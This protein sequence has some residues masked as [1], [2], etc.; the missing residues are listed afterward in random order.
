MAKGSTVLLRLG[1]TLLLVGA[2]ARVVWPDQLSGIDETFVLLVVVA[3]AI[4]LVPWDSLKTFKA[5][6]VELT[7]ERAAVQGAIKSLDLPDVA[8]GALEQALERHSESLPALRGSRILWIDDKPHAVLGERRLFRALGARI[9][10]AVSSEAADQ[11]LHEDPDFDVIVSDVQRIGDSH[12]ENDG[13]PIHEGVNYLV[14]LRKRS[15]PAVSRIPAVFYAAYDDARLEKFTAPARETQP[16]P[17][18]CNDVVGLVS[19]VVTLVS[20]ARARPIAV[21]ATKA[22]TGLR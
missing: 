15:D 16:R 8:L 11:H 9:V 22:P 19:G 14:A 2:L 7:I 5:A 1:S 13:E 12:V 4:Q 6:G 20:E 3:I 10:T 21:P 17:L 18:A